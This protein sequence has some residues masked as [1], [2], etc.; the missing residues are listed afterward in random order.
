[1]INATQAR[2][3]T[4]VAIKAKRLQKN[5]EKELNDLFEARKKEKQHKQWA[6]DFEKQLWYNIEHYAFNGETLLQQ[7]LFSS[8]CSR[9]ILYGKT[10]FLKSYEFAEEL[11]VIIQKLEAD[12]F[13]AD[14]YRK[15][16]PIWTI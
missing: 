9:H 12:G 13:T 7:T 14:I 15:S 3:L 10:N 16:M 11:K 8:E 1:M 5:I 4:S 2:H 6:E